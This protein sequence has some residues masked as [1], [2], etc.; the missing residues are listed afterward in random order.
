MLTITA[1]EMHSALDYAGAIDALRS[2]VAD[3]DPAD[4]PVRI[5]SPL[6]HGEYLLMPSEIGDYIGIKVITV[7]PENPASGKPLVQG[8]VL[9]S[10]RADHT[11]L[12]HLDGAALTAL[13]TPAVSLAGVAGVLR[14]RFPDG[15]RLTVV[16]AGVQALPHVRAAQAILPVT[17]V[18]FGVRTSGRADELITALESEGIPASEAII[19]GDL[20]AAVIESDLIITATPSAEPVIADTAVPAGAVVVA[21]GSHNPQA[22]E[23]PGALLG[24]AHVIVESR[25]SAEAECGDVILAVAEGA[26]KWDDVHTF[27]D[28]VMGGEAELSADRPVV[29]KTS[30]M[31]WEDIA[32]AGAVYDAVTAADSAG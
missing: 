12:A 2:A 14:S 6:T 27:R 19:G 13:R 31:S 16:G 30:G 8:S 20:D 17:S 32:V 15:I 18:T 26:L 9:L 5:S 24:R 10:A 11:P 21:M 25:H 22:R 23:L 3:F 7:T 29:F 28:I 4:D 1:E